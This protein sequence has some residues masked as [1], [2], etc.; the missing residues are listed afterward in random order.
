M[1]QDDDDAAGVLGNIVETPILTLEDDLSEIYPF[2]T[3]V[4]LTEQGGDVEVED[5]A[6]GKTYDVH[7]TYNRDMEQTVQPSVTY[8]GDSPYTDYAVHGDWVSDREWVGT[9][10]ISSVAT[11]GTMIFRT[12]GGCAADD[13]WLVC[14]ADELRFQ[15]NI[16]SASALAMVLNATGGVNRVDLSWAQNDYEV[17]GGYNL[18]R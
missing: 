10:K 18:Y 3:K 1:I 8:G 11:G 16:N 13:N 4:W 5:A 2:V 12:N 14:G 17:L 7:V 9:T 15:F 6:P